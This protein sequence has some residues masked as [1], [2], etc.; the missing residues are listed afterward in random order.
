MNRWVVRDALNP[1]PPFEIEN[2][3]KRLLNLC[4]KADPRLPATMRERSERRLRT[5]AARL[6]SGPYAESNSRTEELTGLN[7]REFGYAVA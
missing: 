7:L 4:Y 2:I 3:N 1:A 6:V 5:T